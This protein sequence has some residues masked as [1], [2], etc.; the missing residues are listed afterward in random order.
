MQL[1]R[2]HALREHAT[3][4]I[5]IAYV[6]TACTLGLRGET[7]GARLLGGL[8][9]PL[10]SDRAEA[11]LSAIA[12]G[13]MALTAI[14]FSLVFVAVQMTGS[15]FGLRLMRLLG[16]SHFLGHALGVFTGSFVYAL[17]AIRTIDLGGQSGI[18]VA[19]VLVAFLWLLGSIAV[20]LLLI[21]RLR[22]LDIGVLLSTLY[23][24]TRH[25]A[26]H[27]YVAAPSAPELGHATTADRSAWTILRHDGH[28]R[29]LLGFDV[30]RLVR[31]AVAA[32]C[33]I[34][35]PLAIGDPVA[36][37]AAVAIISPTAR[38]LDEPALRDALWL[39][40]ERRIDNDPAYGIRL[41]VDVA[42]RALSP[43]INDPTT[44]IMVLDQ[45]DGLLRVLAD[46]RLEDHR[47]LDGSGAVRLVFEGCGWEDF[48]ALALTEID[49]YGR[50]SR[51]VQRRIASLLDDL[52]AVLPAA[53]RAAI[54]R[55][56]T[57]H[58]T[59]D[60]GWAASSAPDRQGLGHAAPL[61]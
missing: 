55:F 58:R 25:A 16:R 50:E 43:A 22:S 28:P 26:L 48:V 57:W 54:T 32:D 39:G 8:A 31:C 23:A 14:L 12:S 44:A 40:A 1:R 41:L 42:I 17:L 51:Q 20:L 6:A 9:S 15:F 45:L 53:R 21:L 49:E 38:P 30:D 61:R 5:A 13:M 7:L 27:V 36:T 33:M 19:V 24:Q 60:P 35:L 4:P 59:A 34:H 46:R 10:A 18:N 56:A 47:V 11:I 52:E 37:G 3:A 29:Y 2:P